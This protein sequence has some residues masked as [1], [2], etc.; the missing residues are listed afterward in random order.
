VP[1]HGRWRITRYRWTIDDPVSV[2]AGNAPLAPVITTTPAMTQ[3]FGPG[4]RT[5]GER[6]GDVY[7]WF[8]GPYSSWQVHVFRPGVSVTLQVTDAAGETA[9]VTRR[10]TFRDP[11]ETWQIAYFWK[12]VWG[13][14]TEVVPDPAHPNHTITV[15]KPVLVDSN[16]PNFDL[17]LGVVYSPACDSRSALQKAG[18]AALKLKPTV[19]SAQ[20]GFLR[21]FDTGA[22]V[23]VRLPCVYARLGCDGVLEVDSITAGRKRKARMASTGNRKAREL[24]I[25]KFVARAGH[26]SA[27]VTINLNSYGVLLARAH[28]LG[29]VTLR[30]ASTGSNGRIVTTGRTIRLR[31]R[32]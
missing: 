3:V 23:T 6:V 27:T 18:L 8:G 32:R 7:A 31:T 25:A 14:Q 30:L 10:L 5:I 29:Q 26:R 9:S 4:Y 19:L 28:K 22:T 2:A 21:V 13:S 15:T 20:S 24:G 1:V 16:V 12:Q 11:E 17:P